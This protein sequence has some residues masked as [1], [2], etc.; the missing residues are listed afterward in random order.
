MSFSTTVF[1][2][3]VCNP[4]KLYLSCHGIMKGRKE[5]DKFS[6]SSLRC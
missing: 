2:V 5:T 4:L 6:N 3:R 1:R